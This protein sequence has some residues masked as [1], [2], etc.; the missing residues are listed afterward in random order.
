MAYYAKPHGNSQLVLLDSNAFGPKAVLKCS[1]M[2]EAFLGSVGNWQLQTGKPICYGWRPAGCFKNGR[3]LRKQTC[4]RCWIDKYLLYVCMDGWMDAW[5]DGW[6]HAC[7]DGWMD[8]CMDGWMDACM[9]GWM[10]TCMDGWMHACMH[11]W[12]DGWMHVCM[13]VCIYIYIRICKHVSHKNLTETFFLFHAGFGPN[14][15]RPHETG[16][17]WPWSAK[18]GFDQFEAWDTVTIPRNVGSL[19]TAFKCQI[20]FIYVSKQIEKLETWKLWSKE[21]LKSN[22]QQYGQ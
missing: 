14:F 10:Y 18:A 6:M 4:T 21:V 16:Q 5:M 12:M 3:N 2:I 17:V 9:D 20:W 8:T 22:F 15:F 11:G 13:Y 1:K 19:G 7:M